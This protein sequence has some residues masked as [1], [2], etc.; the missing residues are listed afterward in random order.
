MIQVLIQ[1]RP[2]LADY[3]ECEQLDSVQQGE[4]AFIVA[5]SGNHWRKI[6]NIY[7]KFIYQLALQTFKQ[8]VLTQ[9]SWQDYRDNT[10]LQQGS[11][12]ALVFYPSSADKQGEWIRRLTQPSPSIRIVV[13][14]GFATEVLS[15]IPLL[16]LDDKFAVNHELGIL[17]CP[18][19][20]YRQ[21]SNNKILYLV[22]LV[23]SMGI[24]ALGEV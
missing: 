13:G 10:L 12:T 2:P 24:D 9:Q 19:F 6:F 7:A 3:Q 16:W 5:E 11:S 14:K 1:N 22:D 23:G 15:D 20:D 4:L 21:L 17:V 18:Y 8:G